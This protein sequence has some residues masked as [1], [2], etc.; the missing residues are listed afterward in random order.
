MAAAMENTLFYE[1]PYFLRQRL[2]FS[3]LSGKSVKIKKIRHKGDEIGLNGKLILQFF[4]SKAGTTE[5]KG[6]SGHCAIISTLNKCLFSVIMSFRQ[7][8]VRR[9]WTH[10][11]LIQLFHIH[12]FLGG[13]WYVTCQCNYSVKFQW[14]SS[15]N[16]IDA[17]LFTKSLCKKKKK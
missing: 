12:T 15:W 3:T 10:L 2:V 9:C 6:L 14:K 17:S 1:G 7:N 5:W 16:P 13:L 8:G 11:F 4:C